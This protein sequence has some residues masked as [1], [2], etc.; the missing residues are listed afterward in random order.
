MMPLSTTVGHRTN[1]PVKFER[2][3]VS[4]FGRTDLAVSP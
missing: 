2:L 4:R 3:P 1:A